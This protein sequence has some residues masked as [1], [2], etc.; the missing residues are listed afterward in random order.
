MPTAREWRRI[1]ADRADAQLAQRAAAWLRDDPARRQTAGLTDDARA[2]A[3]ADLVDALAAGLPDLG[4]GVRRQLLASARVV[5]G[6]TM[7]APQVRRT[8]R[9]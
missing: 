7:D 5:L 8:R 3:L 2:A 1:D 6:E 4:A 9:R